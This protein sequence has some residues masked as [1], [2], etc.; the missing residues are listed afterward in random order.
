MPWWVWG[1]G[2]VVAGMASGMSAMLSLSVGT[3]YGTEYHVLSP[4]Q[5]TMARMLGIGAMVAAVAFGTLALGL[6]A[7]TIRLLMD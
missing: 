4:R 6:S 3:A 7:W 2:A 1:I 5:R